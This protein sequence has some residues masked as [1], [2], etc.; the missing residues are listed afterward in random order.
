MGIDLRGRMQCPWSHTKA[1]EKGRT[2][3]LGEESE[4]DSEEQTKEAEQF[5]DKIW[6][7]K[8]GL[9]GDSPPAGPFFPRPE[10]VWFCQ[11]P[12]SF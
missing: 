6:T 7:G 11:G 10:T 5:W 2:E 4:E 8:R 3:L 12:R 1:V 9:R